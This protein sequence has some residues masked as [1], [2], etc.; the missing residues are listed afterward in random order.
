LYHRNRRRVTSGPCCARRLGAQL[1]QTY[2]GPVVPS[3]LVAHI[4]PLT[5]LKSFWRLESRGHPGTPSG[6]LGS[7]REAFR[8]FGPFRRHQSLAS[9]R[10]LEESR[11][12]YVPRPG[13][14]PGATSRPLPLCASLGHLRSP[15]LW[16]PPTKMH[17]CIP[18]KG[19]P[20]S[21]TI[22][23]FRSLLLSFASGRRRRDHGHPCP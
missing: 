14:A 9:R 13:P 23:S 11:G 19:S 8:M 22:S 12:A 17:V 15:E 21:T 3:G 5:S 1:Y 10:T 7:P 4:N 16:L 18:S 2:W 20:L 6:F